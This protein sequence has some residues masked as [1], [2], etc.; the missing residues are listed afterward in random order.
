[1]DENTEAKAPS[2]PTTLKKYFGF[3]EGDTLKEFLVELKELSTEEKQQL[4][5]G[6][7]NGTLTY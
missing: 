7:L 3:K 5:E 4:A 2:V 6:I 1:M